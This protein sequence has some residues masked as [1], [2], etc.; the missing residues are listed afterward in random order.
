[1]NAGFYAELGSFLFVNNYRFTYVD[2]TEYFYKQ[3]YAEINMSFKIIKF[4]LIA[5]VYIFPLNDVSRETNN[6]VGG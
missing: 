1:M 4:L 2:K 5:I 3:L 6:K